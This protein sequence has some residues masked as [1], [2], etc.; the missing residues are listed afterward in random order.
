MRYVFDIDDTILYSTV[1]ENGEYNLTGCNRPLID[2]INRLYSAGDV[3]I[4]QTGRHWNHLELTIEQLK[5]AG[6]H[7]DTLLMGKP[8]ADFYVDDKAMRPEEF[9][10]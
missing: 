2:K 4:I 10:K 7:Y 3:I 5:G 9:L 1:K 8:V 6:V